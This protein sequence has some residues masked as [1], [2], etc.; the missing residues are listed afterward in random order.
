MKNNNLTLF[1]NKFIIKKEIKFKIKIK[2]IIKHLT[3]IITPKSKIKLSISK[4]KLNI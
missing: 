2:I 4:N 1:L 3:L